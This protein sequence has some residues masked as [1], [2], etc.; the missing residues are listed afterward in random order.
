MR[1]FSRPTSMTF[2]SLCLTLIFLTVVFPGVAPAQETPTPDE[3]AARARVSEAL[4][5]GDMAAAARLLANVGS[6]PALAAAGGSVYFEEL[7]SCGFYPQETRLECTID[8]KQTTGYGEFIGA[9]GSFEFVQFC[10]DW[11]DNGEFT[12]GESVG[13]G[14]VH[15]HDESA[16]AKPPWHYAV[17]RDIDPPGGLRTSTDQPEPTTTRSYGWTRRVRAILSWATAPIGCYF[18]PVWGNTVDFRVRFDPIR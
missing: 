5:K 15:M 3:T 14:I 9:F 1:N 10:V 13:L 2:H 12:E 16:G 7:R 11:D 4:S 8:I 17:Y 18:E 6:S